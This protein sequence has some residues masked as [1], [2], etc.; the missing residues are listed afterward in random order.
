MA[1]NDRSGYDALYFDVEAG[2]VVFV[3]L[4]RSSTIDLTLA[5]FANVLS[6]LHYAGMKKE[7][8]VEIYVVIKPS[9]MKQF[10]IRHIEDHGELTEYDKRWTTLN[11]SVPVLVFEYL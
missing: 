3:R 7:M 9:K 4:M 1:R 6:K 2:Q 8:N 5:V 10:K 11:K